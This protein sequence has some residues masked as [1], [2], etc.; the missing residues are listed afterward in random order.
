VLSSAGREIGRGGWLERAFL[1][2]LGEQGHDPYHGRVDRQRLCGS[3]RDQLEMGM[4]VVAGLACDRGDAAGQPIVGGVLGGVMVLWR[5]VMRG[6]MMM[7]E[8][9]APLRKEK[10][11]CRNDGHEEGGNP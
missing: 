6:R 11:Q 4:P 10:S 3:G 7:R 9:M 8:P 5:I 1:T 2:E